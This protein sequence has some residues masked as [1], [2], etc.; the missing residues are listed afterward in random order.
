MNAKRKHKT[1]TK[2]PKKKILCVF[3]FICFK[4]S[5][6]VRISQRDFSLSAHWNENKRESEGEGEREKEKEKNISEVLSIRKTLE[7]PKKK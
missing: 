1:T 3:L 7:L 6:F 4:T 2:K 5:L